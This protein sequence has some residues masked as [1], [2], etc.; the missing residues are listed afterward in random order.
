MILLHWLRLL[1][2]FIQL[3]ACRAR[4]VWTSPPRSGP[5]VVAIGWRALDILHVGI[6]LIP[7][8]SVI[9]DPSNFM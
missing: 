4:T 7:L 6:F 1:V 8:Y 9:W 5:L 3:G 2:W